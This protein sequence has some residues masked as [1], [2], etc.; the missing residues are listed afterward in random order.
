MLPGTSA[1]LNQQVT[2]S[3]KPGFACDMS[4][5]PASFLI[6]RNA[7]LYRFE[8]GT[9]GTRIHCWLCLK[10]SPNLFFFSFYKAP[11]FLF[12]S[13]PIGGRQ[14]GR[15]GRFRRVCDFPNGLVGSGL[16]RWKSKYSGWGALYIRKQ[17]QT[18]RCP[19]RI[20]PLGRDRRDGL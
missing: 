16:L 19:I 20:H 6:G 15:A 14:H 7:R 18:E 17:K 8:E 13:V 11:V 5:P 9:V 2:T 10:W 12:R 4:T 3:W 1:M